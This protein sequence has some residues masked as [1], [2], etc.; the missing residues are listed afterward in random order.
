MT[1]AVITVV[2]GIDGPPSSTATSGM[3]VAP[4]CPPV[5]DGPNPRIRR[6]LSFGREAAANVPGQ[7]TSSRYSRGPVSQGDRPRPK[8]M[9]IHELELD[10]RAQAG[11]QRGPVSGKD[12]LHK[13][14]V[15]VD[16][17]QDPPT[18]GGAS[19]HPQRGPRLAPA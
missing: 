8:L 17:S 5:W 3:Q 2:V 16:Q 11:E 18:P 14:H 7:I 4:F 15:L 9:A 1:S 12:R 13:E 19:R 6:R 10:A